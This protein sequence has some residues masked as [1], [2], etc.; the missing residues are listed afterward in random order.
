MMVYS[1]TRKYRSTLAD[2]IQLGI[3]ISKVFSEAMW[4]RYLRRGSLMR[5]DLNFMSAVYAH[6]TAWSPFIDH[7][8]S[9][10]NIPKHGRGDAGL[11]L[12]RVVLRFGVLLLDSFFSLSC[13]SGWY[14]VDVDTHTHAH[15]LFIINW[16][17]FGLSRLHQK[18]KHITLKKEVE[19]LRFRW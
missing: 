13:F 8:W 10:I 17:K 1:A 7:L 6:A 2:A 5:C 9:L 11:A 15:T 19:L 16:R 3:I 18:R 12:V 4:W 14:N